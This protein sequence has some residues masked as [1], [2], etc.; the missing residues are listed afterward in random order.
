MPI[1]EDLPAMIPISIAVVLVLIGL[2]AVFVD[3]V[4]KTE[5]NDM[6]RAGLDVL[7]KKVY[8]NNGVITETQLNSDYLKENSSQYVF[9]LEA[10][11]MQGGRTW[12]YGA[13]EDYDIVLSMPF[14]FENSTGDY[15]GKLYVKVRRVA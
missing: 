4:G 15:T 6:H 8:A 2:T 1:A 9:R 14:I 10:K 7:E 12:T 13:D 3:Y 5:A 11:E